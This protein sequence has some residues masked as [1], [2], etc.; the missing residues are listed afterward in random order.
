MRKAR[1]LVMKSGSGVSSE[2]C[3]CGDGTTRLDGAPPEIIALSV[4]THRARP[5]IQAWP[6][7]EPGWR[8]G[9]QC[10]SVR[11]YE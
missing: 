10:T 5:L 2:R 7:S 3:G 8:V 9:D 4:V 1:N 11:G 6:E